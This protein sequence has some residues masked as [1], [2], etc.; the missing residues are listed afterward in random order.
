MLSHGGEGAL[1]CET[2]PHDDDWATKFAVPKGAESPLDVLLPA[3]SNDA[4][5]QAFWE[6]LR[7]ESPTRKLGRANARVARSLLAPDASLEGESAAAVELQATGWVAWVYRCLPGEG[8]RLN[9]PRLPFDEQ[10][11]PPLRPWLE[12]LSAGLTERA[13]AAAAQQWALSQMRATLGASCLL[14]MMLRRRMKRRAL[15]RRVCLL[16]MVEQ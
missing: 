9:P 4:A 3:H 7:A 8:S 15:A 11:L 12:A 16:A 14:S 5:A 6:C 1:H 2:S 13:A 10:A